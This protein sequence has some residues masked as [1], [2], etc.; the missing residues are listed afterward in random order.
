MFSSF[1][2]SS[3]T[4]S[5]WSKV[6]FFDGH[7]AFLEAALSGRELKEQV[8]RLVHLGFALVHP[9]DIFTHAGALATS[10]VSQV[11]RLREV[12]G[13]SLLTETER[14]EI[15]EYARTGMMAAFFVT[16]YE[17]SDGTVERVAEHVAYKTGKFD[18]V[19][20]VSECY[21]ACKQECV[22]SNDLFVEAIC[23]S[24]QAPEVMLFSIQHAPTHAHVKRF[25]DACVFTLFMKRL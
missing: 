13:V 22:A 9:R 4:D 24:V 1:D 7:E 25:I 11:Q 23:A 8:L 6:F 19:K 5:V 14:E 12:H 18:S 15:V 3:V 2:V 10:Y 16:F 21:R 20:T 17:I